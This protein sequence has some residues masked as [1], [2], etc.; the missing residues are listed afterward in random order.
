MAKKNQEPKDIRK[1]GRKLHNELAAAFVRDVK[2]PGRYFD[3]MGLFL[4]VKEAKG[5]QV[6]RTKRSVNGPADKGME[7]AS[8]H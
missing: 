1:G 3:G 7:A 5:K 8:Q 4:L 2:E 6:K